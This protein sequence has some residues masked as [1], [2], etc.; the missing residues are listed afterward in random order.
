MV[1]LIQINGSDGSPS[2]SK[3]SGLQ[4]LIEASVANEESVWTKVYL[5]NPSSS[6]WR[7][8]SRH[9]QLIDYSSIEKS[10]S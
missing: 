9:D 8:W 5:I 7:D 6:S 4:Q 3:I 1:I 10:S 2:S